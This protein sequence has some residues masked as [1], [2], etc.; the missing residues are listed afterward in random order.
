MLLTY[1]YEK[2]QIHTFLFVR[3]CCCVCVSVYKWQDQ[4]HGGSPHHHLSPPAFPSARSLP[5]LCC[6][7]QKS[8]TWPDVPSLLL[9][10]I[11]AVHSV[12]LCQS[13]N[14]NPLPLSLTLSRCVLASSFLPD[15]IS[16]DFDSITTE[17]K[18][19]YADKV[20]WTHT[21][22]YLQ[23]TQTNPLWKKI[24]HFCILLKPRWLI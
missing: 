22:I 23:Q 16:G 2:K 11:S 1:D 21:R 8:D 20:S 24:G 7:D 17:V 4:C 19:F 9:P 14:L 18:A 13:C 10:S 3:L 5:L 15:Y 12:S 6:T